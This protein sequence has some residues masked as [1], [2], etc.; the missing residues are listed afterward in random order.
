MSKL[1]AFQQELVASA[2]P[3]S[4][5]FSIFIPILLD[6]F[7]DSFDGCGQDGPSNAAKYLQRPNSVATR[8]YVR[9]AARVAAKRAD[10][11][12]VGA[13]LPTT[14]NYFL[15]VCSGKSEEELQELLT[16]TKNVIQPFTFT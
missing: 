13:D 16:E 2:P 15:S 12:F 8:Y 5:D 14:Q 10:I 3:V 9:K 11:Q 6:V 4:F 7:M 1:D